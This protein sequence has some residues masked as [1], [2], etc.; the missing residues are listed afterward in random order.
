MCG[1]NV[2]NIKKNGK[3]SVR[4]ILRG[5]FALKRHNGKKGFTLVE[6]LVGVT[7]LAILLPVL[8]RIFILSS[9]LN[10]KANLQGRADSLAEATME[11]IKAVKYD[12]LSSWFVSNGWTVNTSNDPLGTSTEI[13][14]AE[15]TDGLKKL[16]FKLNKYGKDKYMAGIPKFPGTDAGEI[17]LGDMQLLG[18]KQN[19]LSKNELLSR[20]NV[21]EGLK[22]TIWDDIKYSILPN[23]PTHVYDSSRMTLTLEALNLNNI[24]KKADIKIEYNLSHTMIK[25]SYEVKF[26]YSLTS[27]KY[28]Y[29]YYDENGKF[30]SKSGTYVF[31]SSETV[32][33]TFSKGEIE[34]PYN[35]S[36][37]ETQIVYIT[38]TPL[39]ANDQITIIPPSANNVH[40]IFEENKITGSSDYVL[41]E[42]SFKN[43]IIDYISTAGA[44]K[45]I[46]K[47]DTGAFAFFSA[48]NPNLHAPIDEQSV[49]QSEVKTWLYEATVTAEVR[50]NS[51]ESPVIAEFKSTMFG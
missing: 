39:N 18:N 47:T 50:G 19:E 38:Y 36:Y 30:K 35:G 28:N 34:K 40:L 21:N 23:N 6:L 46:K 4:N 49:Y 8:Y 29:L 51:S 5:F 44:K 10:K 27:C 7:V 41:T 3:R 48:N 33:E 32:E 13:Y 31:Q 37:P 26:I 17:S 25:A 43:D 20:L 14:E 45:I 22:Q 16:T 42:N 2:N 11:E 1:S 12:N 9:Q 15:K 24:T